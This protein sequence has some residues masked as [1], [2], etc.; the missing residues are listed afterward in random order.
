[1]ACPPRLDESQHLRT[2]ICCGAPGRPASHTS[3]NFGSRSGKSVRISAA[4][5]PR[6]PRGRRILASVT[7]ANSCA[8]GLFEDFKREALPDLH[9][10]CAEDRA[11]GLRGPPLPSNHLA[12]IFG[13]HSQFKHG[14][15]L[16]IHRPDL[17]LFWMVHECF[18]NRFHELLHGALHC[19]CRGF[20]LSVHLVTRFRGPAEPCSSLPLER[21]K[22]SFGPSKS[23]EPCRWAERHRRAS[24]SRARHS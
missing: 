4:T 23:C 2:P 16:P 1:M 5:S 6:R 20:H 3:R 18:R 21:F 17:N 8:E 22:R 15:L 9:S 13:M 7:P 24:T 10:S 11:D 19:L 14:D 12:Q